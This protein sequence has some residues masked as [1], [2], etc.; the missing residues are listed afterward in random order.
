MFPDW[1]LKKSVAKF[2]DTY[3]KL[4]HKTNPKDVYA[5]F[6]TSSEAHYE[7]DGTDEVMMGASTGISIKDSIKDTVSWVNQPE[8]GS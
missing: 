8:T 6:T 4:T 2:V 7:T 1:L 5:V 3:Y